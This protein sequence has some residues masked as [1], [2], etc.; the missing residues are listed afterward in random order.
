MN[1]HKQT[2]LNNSKHKYKNTHD[3]VYP[4]PAYKQL[5]FIRK[6]TCS[7]CFSVTW[8]RL[9]GFFLNDNDNVTDRG[10]KWILLLFGLL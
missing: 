8:L 10:R 5:I 4:L 2:I 3:Q 7:G 6:C 1:L 9:L